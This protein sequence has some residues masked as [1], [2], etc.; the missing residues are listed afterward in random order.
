MQK[1]FP[2]TDIDFESQELRESPSMKNMIVE[3][4]K[5]LRE[6]LIDMNQGGKPFI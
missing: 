4:L 5:Y 3:N 1:I 6:Q 2:K